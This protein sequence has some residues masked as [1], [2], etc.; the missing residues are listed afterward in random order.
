MAGQGGQG[1]AERH[2]STGWALKAF[3]EGLEAAHA[4]KP[5]SSNPYPQGSHQAA[6]WVGGW[7]TGVGE[8]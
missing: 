4:G 8:R 3:Q 5:F 6:L 1:D 7:Q 2:P